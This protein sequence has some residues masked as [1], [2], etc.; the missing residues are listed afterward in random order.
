MRNATVISEE[1]SRY[2]YSVS[3]DLNAPV[4][5]LVEFSKILASNDA[6]NLNA[7]GKECLYLIIENGRRLQT[8]MEALLQYSRIL[9]STKPFAHVD[10][11][12]VLERA[13][14]TL[15][16]RIEQLNASIS[17]A[18]LPS[19]W[20][21]AEQLTQLIT[22]LFD[23]ALAYQSKGNAPRIQVFAKEQEDKWLFTVADNGIGIPEPFH[24]RVFELFQ[25]LHTDEEYPGIGM[26]LAL[27]RKIIE[28]HRGTLWIDPSAEG[29]A[30]C[31]TL[32]MIPIISNP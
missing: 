20:G 13:T 16:T 31:F 10:M 8:M 23:N 22:I 5:A 26:G 25:R 29:T 32:P 19:V 6:R 24:Q 21:D 11:A 4:R 30:I 27:A 1:F 9:N 17:S 12:R 15:E 2:A 14:A 28:H 18:S 7:E 3:H